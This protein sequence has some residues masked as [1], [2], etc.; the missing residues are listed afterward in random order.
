[1]EERERFIA[2]HQRNLYTMS[3]LCARYGISRK[4]GYKWLARFDE[5]ADRACRIAAGRRMRVRTRSPRTWRP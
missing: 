4:T 3:E 1:M 2:D 5:A